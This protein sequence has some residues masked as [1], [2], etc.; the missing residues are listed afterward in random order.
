MV[1]SARSDRRI[2]RPARPASWSFQRLALQLQPARSSNHILPNLR[3]TFAKRAKSIATLSRL[4]FSVSYGKQRAMTNPNRHKNSR[5]SSRPHKMNRKPES[6]QMPVSHS[7]QRTAPQINRKLS[8]LQC[9][10][11]SIFTFPLSIRIANFGPTSAARFPAKNGCSVPSRLDVNPD[12]C[13][14]Y[15]PCCDSFSLSG[16]SLSRSL[17]PEEECRFS[18]RNRWFIGVAKLS[19]EAF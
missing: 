5:S 10:P 1:I 13:Y 8:G 6:N 18:A 3:L 16:R 14:K 15:W 17:N 2:S 4:E 9:S 12:S 7:K 19:M 11:F